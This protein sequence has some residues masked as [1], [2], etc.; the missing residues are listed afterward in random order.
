MSYS[1]YKAKQ[2]ETATAQADIIEETMVIGTQDF[3]DIIYQ[4]GNN[5]VNIVGMIEKY[6]LSNVKKWRLKL[7]FV[8]N[9]HN[10]KDRAFYSHLKADY[11]ELFEI[12]EIARYNNLDQ[13]NVLNR[14]RKTTHYDPNRLKRYYADMTIP[15]QA[16][17]NRDKRQKTDLLLMD[18]DNNEIPN[19]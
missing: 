12:I 2:T 19:F 18:F 5:H 7:P 13:L 1:D 16:P 10:K 3:F 14:I 6:F 17:E 8:I 11:P 4:P 15:V 9:W